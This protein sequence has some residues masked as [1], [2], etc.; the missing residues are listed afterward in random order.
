M[1]PSS[2]PNCP[3]SMARSGEDLSRAFRNLPPGTLAGLDALCDHSYWLSVMRQA[4]IDISNEDIFRF[5]FGEISK[6]ASNRLAFLAGSG[7][8]GNFNLRY[9]IQQ[10]VEQC[11]DMHS[12]TRK[13][14]KYVVKLQR[15]VEEL[16]QQPQQHQE[17]GGLGGGSQLPAGLSSACMPHPPPPTYPRPDT[18]T[19]VAA[20][21]AAAAAAG[22]SGRGEVGLPLLPPPGKRPRAQPL[23][24]PGSGEAAGGVA[25]TRSSGGGEE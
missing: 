7:E 17:G 6:T 2:A 13:L 3:P 4:E 10:L 9:L 1:D 22:H 19:L 11:S 21:A 5:R 24:P 12:Y 14:E 8:F 25:A 23:S 20:A 15:R 16:E 18:S